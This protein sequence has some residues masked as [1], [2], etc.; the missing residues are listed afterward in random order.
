MII[1]RAIVLA[2]FRKEELTISLFILTISAF[3]HWG[4][5]SVCLYQRP[6]GRH[7]KYSTSICF[8]I[9]KKNDHH[10]KVLSLGD[11]PFKCHI[12]LHHSL[13]DIQIQ[14][15]FPHLS[16]LKAPLNNGKRNVKKNGRLEKCHFNVFMKD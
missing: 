13:Q 2:S 8:D 5:H 4:H 16:T 1:I 12:M 7:K 9:V 3:Q 15:K 10:S 11:I 6:I 14:F